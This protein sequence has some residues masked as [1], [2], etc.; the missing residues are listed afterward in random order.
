[1]VLPVSSNTADWKGA[2]KLSK[3][4]I[5]SIAEQDTLTMPAL[6]NRT[7]KA[8]EPPEVA[9]M[10]TA[11]QA[12]WHFASE[13]F[14]ASHVY[15]PPRKVDVK[16]AQSIDG[17]VFAY[18]SHG[19]ND[20]K[21]ELRILRIGMRR[22]RTDPPLSESSLVPAYANLLRAALAEASVWGLEEVVIWNPDPILQAAC[23]S[24]DGPRGTER[25]RDEAI[26]CLRWKGGGVQRVD[27]KLMGRYSWC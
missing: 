23:S 11:N 8:G 2:T 1:M 21:K 17:N 4:D 13:E 19:L 10:P 5:S 9:I 18:W 6:H 12:D 24:S 20:S 22:Q 26:P 14:V 15:N 16:G 7:V 27:W 3:S 25:D